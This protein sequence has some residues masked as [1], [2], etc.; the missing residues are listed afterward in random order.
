MSTA[1]NINHL[2]TSEDRQR[3][4]VARFNASLVD[5]GQ[6]QLLW[7]LDDFS[8]AS[9]AEIAEMRGRPDLAELIR[10]EWSLVTVATAKILPE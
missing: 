1:P 3:A 9:A 5:A 6:T 7:P 8:A 4:A 2:S 10:Q